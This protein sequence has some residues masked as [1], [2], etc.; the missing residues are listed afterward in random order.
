MVLV[1]DGGGAL[2]QGEKSFDGASRHRSVSDVDAPAGHARSWGDDPAFSKKFGKILEEFGV[3]HA[4]EEH[5]SDV[6]GEDA[7]SVVSA[8]PVHNLTE[9]LED[10]D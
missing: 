2:E 6:V 7:A 3:G 4:G 5:P 10:R 8:P 9:V 1:K